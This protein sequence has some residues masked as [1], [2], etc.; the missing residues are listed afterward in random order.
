MRAK[1]SLSTASASLNDTGKASDVSEE[2]RRM[3]Q[4]VAQEMGYRP[5]LAAR[6]MRGRSTGHIGLLLTKSKQILNSGHSIPIL[7]AFIQSCESRGISYHIEFLNVD[8]DGGFEP[9]KQ[10]VDGLSDGVIIGGY[11]DAALYDYLRSEKI[12]CVTVDEPGEYAVLSATDVGIYH[13]TQHLSALGHR[14]IAYIGGNKHYSTH[15]LGMEGF[16]RAK[17]EFSLQQPDESWMATVQAVDVEGVLAE[18]QAWARELLASKN[19]PTAIVCHGMNMARS[20]VYEALRLNIK[21]PS[22]LSVI[23]LGQTALTSPPKL[24]SIEVAFEAMVDQ[25]V[26]MLLQRLNGTVIPQKAY[27]IPPEIV[28]RDTVAP[29]PA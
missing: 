8:D 5:K 1:V 16:V 13:A 27:H 12:A 17:D 14:K 15:I 6:M 24:S 2:K 29:C 26:S 19:R 28:M 18:S 9:P 22:E 4:K 10:I 23:A 20:V 11:V 3:I 25:A 21:I 7:E